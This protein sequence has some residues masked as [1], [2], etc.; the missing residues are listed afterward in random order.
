M[1]ELELLNIPGYG[2]AGIV[3]KINNTIAKKISTVI[4]NDK[5]Y[6]NDSTSWAPNWIQEINKELK[7]KKEVNIVYDTVH[8]IKQVLILTT[9]GLKIE[10]NLQSNS[11]NYI[12]LFDDDN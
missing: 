1:E 5:V 4:T 6:A 11:K 9:E 3:L 12:W 2:S 8:E 10:I 7:K